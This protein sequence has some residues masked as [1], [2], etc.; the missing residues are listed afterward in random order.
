MFCLYA[1]FW[2]ELASAFPTYL[3]GKPGSTLEVAARFRK[4]SSAAS[5]VIQGKTKQQTN[6]NQN[7]QMPPCW[8]HIKIWSTQF[9]AE[10]S[11][12]R[13]TTKLIQAF[14]ASGKEVSNRL[15]ALDGTN[16]GQGDV[17]EDSYVLGVR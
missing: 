14:H 15:H 5:T 10:A 12:G 6:K 9:P 11:G 16:V 7:Q 13:L 1:V 2:T 3:Q 17:T 8:P 4:F